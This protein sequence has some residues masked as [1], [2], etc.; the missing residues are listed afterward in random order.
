MKKMKCQGKVA[1]IIV[2]VVCL[3]FAVPEWTKGLSGSREDECCVG[4]G[5]IESEKFVVLQLYNQQAAIKYVRMQQE[6]FLLSGT[7]NQER[8]YFEG[9]LYW[10]EDCYF[11]DLASG[12]QKRLEKEVKSFLLGDYYVR[13]DYRTEHGRMDLLIFYCPKEKQGEKFLLL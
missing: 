3:M 1:V 12:E 6:D 11:Y 9:S 13:C 8:H 5:E 7:L 2:F 4:I 10:E